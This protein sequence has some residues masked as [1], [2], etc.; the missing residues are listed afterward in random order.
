[1]S[2]VSCVILESCCRMSEYTL[3]QIDEAQALVMTSSNI[4]VYKVCLKVYF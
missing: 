2:T 4:T 3:G 1:M